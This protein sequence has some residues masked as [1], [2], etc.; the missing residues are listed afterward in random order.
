M[1]DLIRIPVVASGRAEKVK[2]FLSVFENT[3]VDA[4]PAAGVFHRGEYTVGQVKK[5]LSQHGVHTFDRLF[6]RRMMFSK[7]QINW[8][9][10]NGFGSC[11]GSGW[12]D[13]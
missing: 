12:V 3:G 1:K 8:E 7:D 9:K 2:Q 6:W 4:A 10:V 13:T 5:Y 11:C